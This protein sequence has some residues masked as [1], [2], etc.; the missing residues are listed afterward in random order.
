MKKTLG[1][2]RLGSG[3]KLKIDLHGYERA[4]FDI[5]YVWRSTMSAGTLVPFISEIAQ[6]GDTFDIDLSLLI[7][8]H[9]TIGPLFGSYKAQ[10]DVFQIPIRLYNSYLHNNKTGVGLKMQQILLPMIKL[11]GRTPTNS[12]IAD[13]LYDLDNCQVNSSSLPAYLG[14]RGIGMEWATAGTIGH[15]RE[16][17]C[18]PIFCYY[19]IVKQYYCNKQEEIGFVIHTSNIPVLK[20]VTNIQVRQPPNATATTV[21]QQPA[22]IITALGQ[23]GVLTITWTSPNG[24]PRADQILV[25]TNEHG[26]VDMQALAIGPYIT[27]TGTPNSANAPFNAAKWGNI[28]IRSWTYA[29]GNTVTTAKPQMAQFP[30]TNID[31]AREKILTYR[32]TTV[33][34]DYNAQLASTAPY[35]WLF[36]RPNG[37]PNI[38]SSQEGLAV[39]TYQSDQ[40]NN[41]LDTEWIDGP[42]GIN[43]ITAIDTSTGSFQIDQFMLSKKIYDILNRVA[44]SGGTYE[45]WIE[46]VYDIEPYRRSETPMY[47]GGMIQELIF[48][49]VVSNAQ[50]EDQKLGTLA[51]KGKLGGN[52]KGGHIT[53]KC[54][55]ASYIMAIVSLTPRIDYSQGNKWDVAHLRTLDDLHK[56][57]LDQL[58]FQEL[59]TDQMAWWDTRWNQTNS[60]W[61]YRSAGKQPAWLN[62]M[63]NV[64]RTYGN[65]A[66]RE[67]EMFMTLNR[68]Y[69]IN[70]S[71][72]YIKDLTTYIDPSKFNNIFADEALDS[73][74]FW[75]QIGVDMIKRSKM[76]AKV[77]PNV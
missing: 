43:T 46:A 52:K 50:A 76:S 59:I 8:T 55:E 61:D 24:Q 5:S 17:N 49:E 64:N 45:D 77:M 62:Y 9:P 74:N 33:A 22:N 10:L 56:P 3:S 13:T 40:F 25:L 58:G 71:T 16:F 15:D 35:H 20:T 67:N 30:L 14:I 4:T 69:S 57:G 68:R 75:V 26:W 60:K 31:L 41:W 54:D 27:T 42:A 32:S 6:P 73:Q 12:Q 47:C 28:T 2:D 1:G 11:A 70:T 23:N 39:K 44:V 66:I 19:D 63:T 53:I 51:G 29:D 34:F 37:V 7:N 38:L 21:P 65:F 18:I 36:E 72:N 48:E